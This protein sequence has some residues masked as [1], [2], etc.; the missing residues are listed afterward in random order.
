MTTPLDLLGN[1]LDADRL[2]QATMGAFIEGA[3]IRQALAL[4]PERWKPGKPLKLLLAG[5]VGTRNTG[6]DVRVEEMIRQFRTVL[7]D[8]HLE[9]TIMT[10]DKELSAGY[11]RA[12][13]QVT[14]P[15]VFPKFLFDECPKHHGVVAC[16][17]SM[18][19][20]KFADALSTMM[21]GSLGMAAAE[22][23]L[24]VGYGAEAGQMSPGLR[25][26]VERHCK[27][28]LVLC[29]NEPSRRV[30]EDLGIRTRGGT[31]T[32]WTFEPAPQARGAEL[33]RAAGWDGR[34]KVLV[35]CPIN[36][37]WWPVKPDLWRAAERRLTGRHGREHYRSIYFHHKS[38]EADRQYATYLDGLAAAANAFARERPVFPI[39]V[40]M[41]QLDRLAC[42]DLAPKLATRPPLFVSDEHNM[43]D[44][45]SVLRNCS[46]MVSSR[47]HAIVTSMPGRVPS[48]GVTMDERIRNLMNDRGHSD[49]FLEVTETDLA[50]KLL[51]I[52]HRLDREADRIAEDIGRTVPRQLRLMGDMGIDFVDEVARVYPEF[53][54]RD[55]PRSWEHHLPELPPA[56][57]GLLGR[58]PPDFEAS[59]KTPKGQLQHQ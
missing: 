30:L 6:A 51:A 20:S 34:A 33:L 5:Y 17:G 23:K 11:F 3:G 16:E 14:L 29:R 41:E 38:T 55:V 22:G 12:V 32:A 49:L 54:R 4:D 8:E 35:L 36:P 10:V 2:L 52:L 58:Y 7:G 21:A 18:F 44:L 47:F 48:A 45:V 26:F 56:V 19:K 39:L 27:R 37:F 9:L 15:V 25:S 31:D 59:E 57:Q 28:S 1:A 24:S 13:R 53:P 43:Y 46:L 40:G 42:E 50:G